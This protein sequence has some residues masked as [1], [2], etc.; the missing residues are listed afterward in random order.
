[1]S[2]LYRFRY[3]LL[4]LLLLIVF[5]PITVYLTE[6][7]LTELFE[8][9]VEIEQLDLIHQSATLTFEKPSNR[10]HIQ[11]EKLYPDFEALVDYGG[12]IDAFSAFHPLKGE[13]TAQATVTMEQIDVTLFAYKATAQIQVNHKESNWRISGEINNLELKELKKANEIPVEMEGLL[14]AT[15]DVHTDADSSIY[16]HSDTISIEKSRLE[17]IHLALASQD[18]NLLGEGMFD[19]KDID[20][21]GISFAYDQNSSLFNANVNFVLLKTNLELDLHLNGKYKDEIIKAQATIDSGKTHIGIDNF[22]ADINNSTV[23]AKWIFD[24][25]ELSN[26]TILPKLTGHTFQG[27][28]LASGNFSYADKKIAATLRTDSF[29]G[30]LKLSYQDEQIRFKAKELLI[31]KLLHLAM[32]DQKVSGKITGE[33]SWN[34]NG[35]RGAVTIPKLTIEDNKLND[36]HIALKQSA[37]MIEVDI[38]ANHAKAKLK[39]SHTTYQD[40][41]IQTTAKLSVEQL[42]DELSLSFDGVYK[43]SILDAKVNLHS[44]SVDLL[45]AKLHYDDARLHSPF[46]LT[47]DNKLM[48]LD[49]KTTLEGE[50]SYN[51]TFTLHAKNRELGAILDATLKGSEFRFDAKN[52]HTEN[53]YLLLGSK[54]YTKGNLNFY[55]QG[56]P[57]KFSVALHTQQ[58][59]LQKEHAGFDDNVSVSMTGDFSNNT[60][61]LRPYIT[62]STIELKGGTLAIDTEKKRLDLQSTLLLKQKDRNEILDLYANLDMAKQLPAN[63][64]TIKHV[65][66]FFTIKNI[67]YQDALLKAHISADINRLDD[68]P[69]L[70]EQNLYGPF[71]LEGDLTYKAYPELQLYTKS[72]GGLTTLSLIDQNLTL[73]MKDTDP[74]KID[75][76]FHN[77]SVFTQGRINAEALYHLQNDSGQIQLTMKDAQVE[78]IDIDYTLKNMQDILGLNI[79]AM[80][81]DTYTS[82]LGK[83]RK[84]KNLSTHITR[85]EADFDIQPDSILL[86]DTA[87][88]TP[89][90]L[91]AAKGSL[92]RDGMI[93]RLE[94]AIIDPNGCAAFKQQLK[95]NIASPELV[96]TTGA[97]V[98]L[99]QKTPEAILDTGKQILDAGGKLI[100]RTAS[101]LLKPVKRDN[102]TLVRDSLDRSFNVLGAGKDMVV[103]GN[104]DL[105]YNGDIVHPA[106]QPTADR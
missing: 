97:T 49:G 21:Q 36:L 8:K 35:G 70:K 67:S 78:G 47:V 53:I 29:G 86:K 19:S 69:L 34:K 68:Y 64:I 77:N 80:G 5:K 37:H 3:Y 75:T 51:D 14:H 72:F 39:H 23:T 106:N 15:F 61:K 52:I 25:K 38:S 45:L 66:D 50:F 100:D 20:Y 87:L 44:K 10:G 73:V 18:D 42:S 2:S 96:N 6:L 102:V 99:L 1:M 40:G 93:N 88:S 55:A 101:V 30:A 65:D 84:D 91:F 17:N 94:V 57:K 16:I 90:Y 27:E 7:Y 46:Q 83:K 58:L 43:K 13:A 62:L 60:L 22:R 26:F 89:E 48:D 54:A 79:F 71:A 85:L 41:H 103:S 24:A 31:E 9:P 81:K 12:D 74:V 4:V 105:F 98:S 63:N 92:K 33:G 76:M 59:H 28:L 104:C 82:L 11:V 95:G 56:N 32:I